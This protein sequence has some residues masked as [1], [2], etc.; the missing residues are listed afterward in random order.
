MRRAASQWGW[1]VPAVVTGSL[2]PLA[3]MAW[4]AAAGRLGANPIATAL[5]QL[6]LLALVL[7]LASLACT[8]LRLAS[9]W[10][11]PA[12]VRRALGLAAFGAACLHFLVYVALDQGFDLTALI[13][14]LVERPFILVGFVAL[15]LLVPLALTSTKRSI[16]ALG[17][18]AWS[19]L[20]RI[21]YLVAVLGVVHFYMRVK[22]DTTLPIA[23]GALL[24]LLFAVRLLGAYQKRRIRRLRANADASVP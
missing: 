24:V 7:L 9:G 20:H 11:W 15:V 22:Q 2:V 3:V 8:P 21:A 16:S 17:Y 6:G 18:L 13:A 19:R 14:D 10:T 12:R 23:L 5:N 1:L 4:R